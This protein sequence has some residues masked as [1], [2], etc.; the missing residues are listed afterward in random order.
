VHDNA[1]INFP[2][3]DKDVFSLG[4][5]ASVTN[6]TKDDSF[7][8]SPGSE[9][10]DDITGA[11][12]K[13][14][15]VMADAIQEEVFIATALLSIYIF[16]VLIGLT[17]ALICMLGRDKTRGEGGPVYAGTGGL[18][19]ERRVPISPR[20]NNKSKFPTFGDGE[21]AAGGLEEGG[22]EKV[23]TAGQRSIG[24]I[25]K[26]HERTSSYGYVGEKL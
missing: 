7:L 19:G 11:V 5:A 16:I 22:S 13:L 9:A 26:G 10:A 6:S 15:A 20:T 2:E 24:T 23:G 25:K 12:E 17:R 3:F 4:A 8:S 18:T 14:I 21:W 1:H